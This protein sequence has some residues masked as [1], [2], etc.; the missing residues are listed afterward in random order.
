MEE[1]D[2]A[3]ADSYF[4]I[5]TPISLA[6]SWVVNGAVVSWLKTASGWKTI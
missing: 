2:L 5:D 3:V 1:E 6:S 4:V